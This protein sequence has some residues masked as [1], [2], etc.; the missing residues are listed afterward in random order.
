MK[1][2]YILDISNTL[3]IIWMDEHNY[4]YQNNRSIALAQT[5]RAWLEVDQTIFIIFRQIRQKR[6]MGKVSVP[7]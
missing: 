7:G 3:Q 4:H 1:L 6:F 5:H 2:N